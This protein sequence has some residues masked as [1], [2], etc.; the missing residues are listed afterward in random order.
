MK[1]DFFDNMKYVGYKI[2]N[3]KIHLQKQK[4]QSRT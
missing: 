2:K 3:K 1:N 4:K